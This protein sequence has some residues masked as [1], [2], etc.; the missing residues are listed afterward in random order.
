MGRIRRITP[1][2]NS[3]QERGRKWREADGSWRRREGQGS[4]GSTTK[5]MIMIMTMM[6]MM[7][8]VRRMSPWER[9]SYREVPDRGRDPLRRLP[10]LCTTTVSTSTVHSHHHPRHPRN[11]LPPPPPRWGSSRVD[12]SPPR[13]PPRGIIRSTTYRHRRTMNIE[14][15]KEREREREIHVSFDRS[16]SPSLPSGPRTL[17]PP[18]FFSSSLRILSL[19][20]Q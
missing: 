18:P 8:M 6:M 9:D 1:W 12:P 3:D 5:M 16:I 19:L 10:A 13:M 15:Y 14:R 7:M 20:A 4:L 2:A 11:P 17:R